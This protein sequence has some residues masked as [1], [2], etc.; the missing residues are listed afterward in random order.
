MTV[1]NR[2]LQ[3]ESRVEKSLYDGAS[4]RI[5]AAVV[6]ILKDL[7]CPCLDNPQELSVQSNL[8]HQGL[9]GL[10]YLGRLILKPIDLETVMIKT[11]D[12][13]FVTPV[14]GA[15]SQESFELGQVR[16]QIL[17]ERLH[18]GTV[19]DVTCFGRQG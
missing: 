4:D 16:F 7:A 17:K 13:V 1:L 14:I 18:F 8:R 5:P 11:I 19:I 3:E 15:L 6:R 2:H 10:H 12:R 9:E